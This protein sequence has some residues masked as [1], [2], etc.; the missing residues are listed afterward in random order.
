[1]IRIGPHNAKNPA[2]GRVSFYFYSFNYSGLG[3]TGMPSVFG[4][5]CGS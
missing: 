4:L 1:M 3:I 5:F 2:Q